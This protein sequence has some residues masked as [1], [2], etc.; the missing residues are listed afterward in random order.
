MLAFTVGDLQELLAERKGP[1]VSIFLPTHRRPDGAKQD[2]LRFKNL[3][4]DARRKLAAVVAPRA[5]PRLLAPFD[6][7]LEDEFWRD[8]LDGLAAFTCPG[9]TRRWRVAMEL[10]ERVIVAANFHVRPLIRY[11]QSDHRWYVLTLSKNHAAFYEGGPAGLVKKLVPGLPASLEEAVGKLDEKG[12]LS[13]HSSGGGG[14]VY[15]GSSAPRS[16]REDLA[17]W[18]RAAD[19]AI[20][21]LLADE[22]APLIVAG[23][24]RYHA[25]YRS[26]SRYPH[27]AGQGVDGNFERAGPEEIHARV[28]PV[29]AAAFRAREDEAIAEYQRVNGAQRSSDDIVAIGQAAVEGRVR[30]LLIARGRTVRGVFDRTTGSIGKR[31][32]R[33]D[34][35]GDDVLDD[36][37][38]AVLARGGA[39]LVVEK[40]RMPTRSPVAAVLRW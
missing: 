24:T 3:V 20:G 29:A 7:L 38:E 35:F 32:A 5:V 39:V 11:L 15:H 30:R 17:R 16:E 22:H 26:V 33:E 37:A 40:E 28:A 19:Q 13:S 34:A 14:L 21:A 2:R 36:L 23:V 10:P 12:S 6:P 18:F 4:D 31:D 8:R 9:F 25:I 27:L 1:C